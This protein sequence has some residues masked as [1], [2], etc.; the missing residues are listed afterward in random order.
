MK[1]LLPRMAVALL[2]ALGLLSFAHAA[3]CYRSNT[4]SCTAKSVAKN[5]CNGCGTKDS[6]M[7]LAFSTTLDCTVAGDTACTGC[8]M[9]ELWYT[10]AGIDYY[11]DGGTIGG[12]TVSCTQKDV[13][14][15]STAPSRIVWRCEAPGYTYTLYHYFYNKPCNQVSDLDTPDGQSSQSFIL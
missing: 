7:E 8:V 10:D 12:D 13:L 2:M 14:F 11:W 4:V 3:S 9:W 6:C 15:P 5:L 1:R